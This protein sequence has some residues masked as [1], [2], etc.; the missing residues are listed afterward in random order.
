VQVAGHKF[1]LAY[2][3]VTVSSQ[4]TPITDNAMIIVHRF[5]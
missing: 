1:T 4:G 3:S 2:P 5:S